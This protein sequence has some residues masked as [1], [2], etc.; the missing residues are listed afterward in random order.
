MREDEQGF[1]P[2]ILHSSESSEFFTMSMSANITSLV[3]ITIS[4]SL[5]STITTTVKT[6]GKGSL[7]LSF[8]MHNSPQIG[9]LD[10]VILGIHKGF[11]RGIWWAP[12]T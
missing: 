2:F 7:S 6:E 5:S 4:V 11:L 8:R 9:N 1:L 3:K 10:W 12:R